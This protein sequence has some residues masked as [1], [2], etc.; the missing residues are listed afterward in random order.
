MLSLVVERDEPGTMEFAMGKPAD[1]S[2]TRP[3]VNS[4]GSC[5]PFISQ[6]RSGR[7]GKT[8]AGA[9]PLPGVPMAGFSSKSWVLLSL[10]G[11][12]VL[13]LCSTSEGE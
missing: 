3:P 1:D 4:R 13:L 12:L 6:W 10:L 11:L 9:Q 5:Q 7:A 8:G 2:G